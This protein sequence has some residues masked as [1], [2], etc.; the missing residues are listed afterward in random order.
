MKASFSSLHS[1]LASSLTSEL[2]SA[3]FSTLTFILITCSF[4]AKTKEFVFALVPKDAKNSYYLQ[5]KQGCM[6]AAKK[7]EVTC[8]YR[9]PVRSDVRLQDM[10]ITELIELKVDAIAVAVTQSE[11]LA[12]HSFQ[13]AKKAG[14]PIITFDADFNE[15]SKAKDPQLRLAYV[16]SNNFALGKALG[17]QLLLHHPQG[18][19]I[20]IQTGRPD[21]HN[22]TL[23]ILGLRTALA[24][25]DFSLSPGEILDHNNG[26]NEVR[27]PYPSYGRIPRALK[28]MEKV[29]KTDNIAAFVAVGGWAQLDDSAYRQMIF[30]LKN[31]LINNKTSVVMADTVNS[32]LALLAD[33]LSHVNIGQSPYEMGNMAMHILHNIVSNKPFQETT[34]TPLTYCTQKNYSTCT[35]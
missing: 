9:G 35:K 11:F 5:S 32:Q 21:S 19:N 2:V 20:V 4:K 14:I 34:Y 30:P 18:G 31:K 28:Q 7:L 24:G 16:G 13:L 10:I 25:K 23:R 17:Q 29:L 3:L 6:H 12:Q 1:N 8:L 15:L 27:A 22:L 33:N 26:W